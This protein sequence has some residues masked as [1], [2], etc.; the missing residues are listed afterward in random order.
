MPPALDGLE[1][2]EA[3]GLLLACAY[4][5]R[6]AQRRERGGGGATAFLLSS[7]TGVTF[8]QRSEDPLASEVRPREP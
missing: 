3:V 2:D 7:G 1:A 6:L 4:P 8:P 5:D